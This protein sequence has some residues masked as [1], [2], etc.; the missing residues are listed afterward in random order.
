MNCL[1]REEEE[2]EEEVV[3]V[4]LVSELILIVSINSSPLNLFLFHLPGGGEEEEVLKGWRES[5]TLESCIIV[6]T[7]TWHA[8]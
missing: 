3:N 2:E 6:R 7:E 4:S 5:D 1:C 8:D